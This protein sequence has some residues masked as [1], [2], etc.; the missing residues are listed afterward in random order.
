MDGRVT[1]V[2]ERSG[3]G[4]EVTDGFGGYGKGA[5]VTEMCVEFTET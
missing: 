4:S 3:M 5:E 2:T 1:E